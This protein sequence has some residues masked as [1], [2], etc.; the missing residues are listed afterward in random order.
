[1]PQGLVLCPL[2]FL[3]YINDLRDNIQSTCKT[4]TDDTS[5]FSHVFHKCKSQIV[6]NND[7]QDKSN[8]TFQWKMQFNP[9]PKK[10]AQEVYF[11]KKSNNENTL[12]IIFNNTK[13]VTCTTQKYLGLSLDKQLSSQKKKKN[14]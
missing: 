6:L 10:Q 9:E 12:P 4:F 7:L 3:I 13:A 5:L 14:E 1:M 8:W 11:T 2:L